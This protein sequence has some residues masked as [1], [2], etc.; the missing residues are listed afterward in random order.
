MRAE[1]LSLD[2]PLEAVRMVSTIDGPVLQFGGCDEHGYFMVFCDHRTEG[3]GIE[4]NTYLQLVHFAD[5]GVHARTLLARGQDEDA[6]TAAVSDFPGAEPVMAAAAPDSVTAP[7]VRYA[8]RRWL[9]F[10]F[11]E[12]QI[13]HDGV[14]SRLV[15][16]RG[17]A[18]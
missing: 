11:T 9:A 7:L 3:G 14:V 5:D 18:R 17:G 2:A 1:G 12:A 4:G 13:A 8:Q 10:P 15:L 16:F 6:L